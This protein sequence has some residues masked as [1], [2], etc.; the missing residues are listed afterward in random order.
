MG[1]GPLRR[2]G[3]L[4]AVPGVV[5]ADSGDDVGALADR[6]DHGAHEEAF[7]LVAGGG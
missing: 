4:Q 6:F 3:E 7:L 1:S 5:G 2:S